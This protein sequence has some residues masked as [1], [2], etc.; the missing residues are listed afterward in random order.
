M[1]GFRQEAVTSGEPSGSTGQWVGGRWDADG[2]RG[3]GTWER[4][5]THLIQEGGESARVEGVL[6]W[7]W[8]WRG[9]EGAGPQ[10]S[11][12]RTRAP[13]T[14]HVKSQVGRCVVSGFRA[15]IQ[16]GHNGYERKKGSKQRDILFIFCAPGPEDATEERCQLCPQLLYRFNTIHIKI[17]HVLKNT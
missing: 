14:T 16:G 7:L 5:G 11:G 6:L 9:E 2:T 3:C 15:D 17:L 12:G 10:H 4:R 13:S 8:P 1:G